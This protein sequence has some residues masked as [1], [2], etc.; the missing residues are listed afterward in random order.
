MAKT[1]TAP[2]FNPW[3]EQ[4]AL[5]KAIEEGAVFTH[6][7]T[8]WKFRVRHATQWS[9]YIR[10]ATTLVISRND[11]AEVVK[12]KAAGI[13]LTTEEEA[14]DAKASLEIGIRGTLIKWSGVTDRDG[15]PLELS[16]ANA[17]KLFGHM[18]GLW[19]DV[20]EFV[21]NPASF[22]IKEIPETSVPDGVDAAGNSPA[23]SDT[24]PEDSA[25]S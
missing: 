20:N 15:K 25:V 22:G 18:H 5:N 13:K 2:T 7:R 1:A 21:S 11:V 6:K 3:E 23:T 24:A 10:R 19:L 4:D 16:V 17:L 12:K 9:P 14:I 8:G